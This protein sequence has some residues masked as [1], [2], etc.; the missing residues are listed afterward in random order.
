MSNIEKAQF[1]WTHMNLN[2]AFY[3]QAIYA[4]PFDSEDMEELVKIHTSTLYNFVSDDCTVG[5][6]GHMLA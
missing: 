6:V 1:T 5:Y 4:H 3:S 2:L